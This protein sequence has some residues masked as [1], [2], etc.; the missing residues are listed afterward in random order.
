MSELVPLKFHVIIRRMEEDRDQGYARFTKRL[1]PHLAV[2]CSRM[3]WRTP[4]TE[5]A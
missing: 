1:A 4:V 3:I 2:S 5:S